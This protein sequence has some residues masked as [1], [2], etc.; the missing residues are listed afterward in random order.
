MI[1]T[2]FYTGISAL[3]LLYFSIAVIRCRVRH[4]VVLLDGGIDILS[5]HCRAHANFTEYAPIVLLLIS[6]GEML[7]SSHYLLH[8]MGSAFVLG[9]ILHFYSLTSREVR[10]DAAGEVDIRFRQ[11]GMALTFTALGV[12][13]VNALVV[14]VA[15]ML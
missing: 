11:A 10:A 14:S 3:L 4:R 1:I 6:V 5:R 12:G 2:A 15:G 7:H 9:R 8:I 13:A